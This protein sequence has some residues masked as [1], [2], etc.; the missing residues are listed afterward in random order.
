MCYNTFVPLSGI[1][2]CS[3][4]L[5]G[6][7]RNVVILRSEETVVILTIEVRAKAARHD[8]RARQLAREIVYTITPTASSP[9]NIRTAQLYRLSVD[10]TFTRSHLDTL[11]SQLLI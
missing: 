6:Q 9:L 7:E 10:E 1:F 5:S 8:V 2:D 11:I 3:V 4:S